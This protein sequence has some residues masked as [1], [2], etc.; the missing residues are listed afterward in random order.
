MKTKPSI[1][2]ISLSAAVF[3]AV[4]LPFVSWILS[5]VGL[6]VGSLL[7][8][9]GLRW[10]FIHMPEQFAN[11]YVIVS[12]MAISAYASLEYVHWGETESI[13]RTPLVVCFVLALFMDVLLLL[14]AFHP[15]S[16]LISLTGRLNPSPFL[17][18]LPFVLCFGLMFV[19][20]VYG[21]LTHRITSVSTFRAFLSSGFERYGALMV[22]SMLLSF[23]F[24]CIRYTF[25]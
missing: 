25:F 14:A 7:S 13:Y 10:L 12:V 2:G 20:Y 22:L 5:A 4:V 17:H 24:F 16:P 8:D 1:F 23:I 19:A 18:G 9:D 6:P 11:Y 3:V 21:V 15:H